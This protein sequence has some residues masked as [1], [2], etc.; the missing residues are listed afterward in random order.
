M[1]EQDSLLLDPLG[2]GGTDVI[3][4]QGVQHHGAHDA[5]LHAGLGQ[6]A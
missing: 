6:S 3:L 1:V 4:A 2:V 5:Q